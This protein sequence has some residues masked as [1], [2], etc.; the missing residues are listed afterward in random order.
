VIATTCEF[1]GA[2]R[3]VTKKPPEPA[4]YQYLVVSDKIEDVQHADLVMVQ[5]FD[6]AQERLKKK[7]RTGAGLEVQVAQARAMDA[8]A[9]AR[10]LSQVRDL[11]RF[12]RLARCQLVISSGSTSPHGMVSGRSLDALLQEC[13]IDPARYWAELERWLESRTARRVST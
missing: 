4:K 9:V 5:N 7:I 3:R 2:I 6:R 8:R 11:Y 13:G 12:C 10:W 1:A